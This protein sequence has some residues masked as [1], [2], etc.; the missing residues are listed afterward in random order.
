MPTPNEQLKR[1]RQL[2]GW[3]QVVVA[4]KL[5]GIPDYYISR[6]ERGEVSPSPFYQQQL[7]TIFGKTAEELGFLQTKKAEPITLVPLESTLSDSDQHPQ[8]FPARRL[9]DATTAKQVV[10]PSLLSRTTKRIQQPR[11]KGALLL[12]LLLLFALLGSAGLATFLLVRRAHSVPASMAIGSLHFLSSGQTSEKSNQGIADEIQLDLGIYHT[13]AAGKSDYAWLLPDTNKPEDPTVLLGKISGN[14]TTGSLTY[15]DAQHLNLL[16]TTSRV[17]ITEQDAAIPP[18]T[19]STDRG[20]WRYIGQIPQIVPPREQYS[21][22]DHLRHLLSS[23]PKLNANHLAGG[24]DIWFAR[25]MQAINSWAVRAHDD[26]QASTPPNAGLM[27]QDTVCLLDY[28]EGIP[29]VGM[30]FPA[31]TS[32][33][34]SVD[35][36]IGRIGLLETVPRQEPP[37]YISHIILHLNGLVASPGADS[38]MQGRTAQ[39]ITAMNTVNVWLEHALRDARQLLTMTDVQLQQQGLSLLNDMVMT[40]NFA[41]NGRSDPVTGNSQAGAA[42]I[43][44]AIQN[45]ATITIMPYTG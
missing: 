16:D 9:P 40:V 18:L 37:G 19:P 45:L 12:L 8:I 5:G 15:D 35:S 13:P 30:D 23:D 29:S 41:L 32:C 21:L 34:V 28:L 31:T 3:S 44:Q 42:W 1:E 25:N 33:P 43:Y 11:R 20:T 10:T 26:W 14:G 22:L 24:L 2:R 38:A 27:R 17:L 36:R 4:E 6:W 7:C 39:I